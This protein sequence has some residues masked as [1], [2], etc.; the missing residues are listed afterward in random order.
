MSA[1]CYVVDGA[2][3]STDGGDGIF[4]MARRDVYA[5]RSFEKTLDPHTYS[6]SG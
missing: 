2:N 3:A 4:R 5:S 1:Q 6:L